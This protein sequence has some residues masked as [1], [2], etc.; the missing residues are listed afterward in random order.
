[1]LVKK[2]LCRVFLNIIA[3]IIFAAFLSGYHILNFCRPCI[4]FPE[5]CLL[6]LSNDS[7]DGKPSKRSFTSQTLKA[8]T[9]IVE[10][11]PWVIQR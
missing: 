9:A 1:M 11:L 7:R 3:D 6:S 8:L 2:G 10:R 5:T 4:D